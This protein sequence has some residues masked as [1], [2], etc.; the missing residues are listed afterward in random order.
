MYS[1][2]TKQHSL[3][4]LAKTY[5]L[6]QFESPSKERN[7]SLLSLSIPGYALVASRSLG[8]SSFSSPQY[9]KEKPPGTK[10]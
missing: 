4:K 8:A 5:S 7:N 1:S 2:H 6:E 10:F 9:A 3:S